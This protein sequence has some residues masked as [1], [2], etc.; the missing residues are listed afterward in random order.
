VAKVGENEYG[1]GSLVEN[2]KPKGRALDV[3]VPRGV[4]KADWNSRYRR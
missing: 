4:G 2:G 3:D 1:V